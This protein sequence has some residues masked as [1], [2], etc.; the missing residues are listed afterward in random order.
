MRHDDPSDSAAPRSANGTLRVSRPFHAWLHYHVLSH[1]DLG[2]S[3]VSLFDPR[4]RW[5]PWV[6]PL[7]RALLES[8]GRGRAQV[9]PL[10]TRD[11]GSLYH[12]AGDDPLGVSLRDAW[13]FEH[14]RAT[15]EWQSDERYG[16]RLQRFWGGTADRLARCRAT[17]WGGAA[18]DLT[19]LDV[20]ALA[21]HGRGR[22]VGHRRFVAADLGQPPEHVLFRVLHEEAHAREIT[23]R[24]TAMDG[25]DDW[26]LHGGLGATAMQRASA[27]IEAEAPEIRP[28]FQRW[29]RAQARPNS[30]SAACD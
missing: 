14:G 17:L 12:A 16:E 3:A 2:P 28:A 7:R 24:A 25:G 15:A 19:I 23:R 9:L 11:Y 22:T 4:R 29:R 27:L 30:R 1:V 10:M 26:T 6:E 21:A 8:P 18:P 5:R 13:T 20:P